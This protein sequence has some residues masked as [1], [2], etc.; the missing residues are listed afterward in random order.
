MNLLALL[1]LAS[2]GSFGRL[3][4]SK[5]LS[6]SST[7]LVSSLQYLPPLC[8]ALRAAAKEGLPVLVRLRFCRTVS[9][10]GSSPPGAT[11]KQPLEYNRTRSARKLLPSREYNGMTVLSIILT[12]TVE[13]AKGITKDQKGRHPNTSSPPAPALTPTPTTTTTTTTTTST[14]IL[15]AA[16]FTLHLACVTAPTLAHKFPPLA[17]LRSTSHRAPALKGGGCAHAQMRPSRTCNRDPSPIT[18]ATGYHRWNPCLSRTTPAHLPS[19]ASN[20]NCCTAF[21][22]RTT[23]GIQ[24][25]PSHSQSFPKRFRSCTHLTST[26][27]TIQSVIA[28]VELEGGRN[29]VSMPILQYDASRIGFNM[30]IRRP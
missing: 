23:Y 13:L 30:P 24:A 28:F 10:G 19:R 15:L 2:S 1:L 21:S 14:Q 25:S 18:L 22:P 8:F 17:P 12:F 4:Q 16:R 7:V 3:G 29:G 9:A 27:A 6:G 20:F 26:E 5:S 11:S